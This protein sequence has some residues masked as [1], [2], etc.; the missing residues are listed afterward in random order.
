MAR[1]V[2]EPH[3]LLRRHTNASE[4]LDQGPPSIYHN[5]TVATEGESSKAC[6]AGVGAGVAPGESVIEY[7]SPLNVLKDTYDY[8]CY[9]GKLSGYVWLVYEVAAGPVLKT[10]VS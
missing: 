1:P 7:K 2:P 4:A 6:G 8:S 10:R 5:P 3:V 9:S